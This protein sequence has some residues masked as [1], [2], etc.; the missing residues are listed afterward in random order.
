MAASVAEV[1]VNVVD[2]AHE[3]M[4]LAGADSCH[5]EDSTW[6]GRRICSGIVRYRHATF[7]GRAD[8]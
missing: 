3:I 4:R 2:G 7:K 5:L 8:R 6:F 1:G